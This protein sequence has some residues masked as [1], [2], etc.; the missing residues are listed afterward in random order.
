MND[1]SRMG[2]VRHAGRG[3][4]RHKIGGD[5]PE[6]QNVRSLMVDWPTPRRRE[7][8]ELVKER[9]SHIETIED[10]FST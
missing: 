5:E 2:G 1:K 9:V 7:R 8:A 10:T 6:S 4:Y 3:D